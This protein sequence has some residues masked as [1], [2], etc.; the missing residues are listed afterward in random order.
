[1]YADAVMRPRAVRTAWI[2]IVAGLAPFLV[3]PSC[4]GDTV[5]Q[6]DGYPCTRNRDCERELVCIG[7]ICRTEPTDG[8]VSD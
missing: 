2:A 7:G 4:G 8:A 5:K 1:M 6:P 3:A